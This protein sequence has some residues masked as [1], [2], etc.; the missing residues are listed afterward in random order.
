M[1]QGSLGGFFCSK[2]VYLY[3]Y[4]GVEENVQQSMSE[5]ISIFCSYILPLRA[6]SRYT[7]RS[8]D[9]VQMEYFCT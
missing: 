4:I 6:W 2:R 8:W 3:I 9:K 5:P 7:D 1:V